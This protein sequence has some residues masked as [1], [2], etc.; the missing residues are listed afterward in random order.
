MNIKENKN[1]ANTK[2]IILHVGVTKT[3]STSIQK[4]LFYEKNR[5]LLA[6][7]GYLY[8]KCWDPN[9][10]RQV[11]SAFCLNREYITENI[12]SEFT[13]EETDEYNHKNL[14][15]LQKEIIDTYFN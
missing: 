5:E 10:S 14:K 1:T 12:I 8:P 6:K 15:L 2:T 7:K 4:T 3:G 11:L 9:H 13:K